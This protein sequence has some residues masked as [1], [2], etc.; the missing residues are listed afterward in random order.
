VQKTH[1]IAMQDESS[2]F[3]AAIYST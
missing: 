1:I 3:T 2:F